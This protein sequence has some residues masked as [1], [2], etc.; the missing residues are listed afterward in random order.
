MSVL[1]SE[2]NFPSQEEV[3]DEIE[4]LVASYSD[5]S[6]KSLNESGQNVINN[7]VLLA[8]VNESSSFDDVGTLLYNNIV[9]MISSL[10][11]A[12]KSAID[13]NFKINSY[14]NECSMTRRDLLKNIKE[15]EITAQRILSAP[16][17]STYDKRIQ[18]DIAE[19]SQ[20][21]REDMMSM[22]TRSNEKSA[23]YIQQLIASESDAIRYRYNKQYIAAL[24]SYEAML[25]AKNK[26]IEELSQLKTEFEKQNVFEIV[27]SYFQNII[28]QMINKIKKEIIPHP[29]IKTLLEGTIK[30][31]STNEVISNPLYGTPNLTA[32]I[33]ILKCNFHK[34]SMAN[35]AV[36]LLEAMSHN[37]TEEETRNNPKK[38]VEDIEK[39]YSKWVMKNLFDYMNMDQFFSALVIKGLHYNS[40]I[41]RDVIHEATKYADANKD[42]ES[43]SSDMGMYRHIT[44]FICDEQ[45]NRQ[46]AAYQSGVN[47]ASKVLRG[48]ASNVSNLTPTEDAAAAQE[49]GKRI[50]GEV[51]KS[52]GMKTFNARKSKVP[53]I[54]VKS[55][56]QICG[57][58]FPEP[59]DSTKTA[60]QPKCFGKQCMKCRYYGHTSSQ[61]MQSH[62]VDGVSVN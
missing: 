5:K 20:S 18:I 60:C 17:E 2:V 13:S 15:R 62:T 22:S 56:A 44:K 14:I 39:I 19:L 4:K 57:N 38:I 47:K 54:A 12:L 29:L 27:L 41:R 10:P 26:A 51:P 45:D 36:N 50:A 49:N 23:E 53:Y 42:N 7:Y 35:F 30:L 28:I 25:A 8:G 37:L 24:D 6:V 9:S 3:I 48:R 1:E 58:C 34:R 43:L 61:C 11:L 46:L 59:A 52:K 32:I 31:Q 40:T 33:E 55:E 16:L 21:K